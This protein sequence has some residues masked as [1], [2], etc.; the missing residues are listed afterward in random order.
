[1]TNWDLEKGKNLK[2]DGEWDFYWNRLLSYEELQKEKPDLLV[3][4]PKTWNSY[5]IEGENLSGLGFATY[6]LH[7]K[8]ALP[9]GTVLGLRSHTFSSAYNLYI[10][11]SL[12]ASNGIVATTESEEVGEYQPQ[13]IM[14]NIPASEFDIIIHVSNFQFARGGFWYSMTI[15]SAQSIIDLHAMLMS[16]ASFLLGAMIITS[17]FF[18]ALY[19]LQ[20]DLKYSLYFAL[21]CLVLAILAD[22]VGQLMISRLIKGISLRTVI[23][24]WYSSI[25]WSQYLFIKY[26]HELF[27][28]TFSKIVLRILLL[29]ALLM[30]IV[31]LTT[32]PVIYTNVGLIANYLG[33]ISIAFLVT[34]VLIG[35]QRKIKGSALNALSIVII[36][37]TYVHDVL[38]LTNKIRSNFGELFYIGLFLVL[39]LQMIIQAQRIKDY[40]EEKVSAELSFLQAQIKPHF[41]YNSINTFISISRYDGEEARTLLRN[42]SYYLR[43][44]FDFKGMSQFVPLKNEIELA[45]AYIE[46]EKARFE[47]RLEVN[48]DIEEEI[49]M[50]VPRITLQPI[51]ENAIIHGILPKPEGGKVEII[52]KK[53]GKVFT[54]VVKDNGIGMDDKK[55]K[56]IIKNKKETGIGL[57][58]IE[59]RLQKLYKKGLQIKCFPQGGTEVTWQIPI[60]PNS[61]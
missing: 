9:A 37:I 42:F 18:F 31:Y 54:F 41:L 47:E 43:R 4:V 2:L 40:K 38:Y 22:M 35:Y 55:F 36:L 20:R 15:G 16:K 5:E 39:F 49:E 59:E 3:Y 29:Y 60:K 28:T 21:L 32:K 27:S 26:V 45:R 52:I 23:I 12:V 50:L 53:E 44:S 51:V 8:T 46:I 48:F 6:K 14:F 24:I 34:I 13:A 58:N 33:M 17:L 11:E 10:N 61:L 56:E 7:V 1:M 57:A 30:Q 19:I 25:V